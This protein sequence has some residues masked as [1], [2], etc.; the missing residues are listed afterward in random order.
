MRDILKHLKRLQNQNFARYMH[1]IKL[2]STQRLSTQRVKRQS[3]TFFND[4]KKLVN[5]FGS[6]FVSNKYDLSRSK[7]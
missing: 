1:N 7:P 2:N 3:S 4:D 5:V 6:S